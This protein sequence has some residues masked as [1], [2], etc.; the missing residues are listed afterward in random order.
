LRQILTTQWWRDVVFLHWPVE[1][2][3]VRPLMPPGVEP[4]VL[5]GRTYV[6]LIAFLMDQVGVLRGP[7]LPYLGRF[8]ETNVRLYSVD[9]HGRPGIVF[10]SMDAARLLPVRVGRAGLRLPYAWSRMAV[11]R[12]GDEITYVCRRRRDDPPVASR[13]RIRVGEA[14]E[15]PGPL[16]LFLTARWALHAAW[17]GRTLYLPTA[18]PPWPL[19]RASLVDLDDTLVAA[20]GLEV[21]AGPPVS[22]LYSPGVPARF[23]WPTV[24]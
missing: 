14:I 21:P 19:R 13:I 5:D 11:T 24:V 3:A 7:G 2:A 17:R 22:V 1:P 9:R 4:D 20:A 23:G 16:D 15:R 10:R 8:P 12:R 18:H 6:G